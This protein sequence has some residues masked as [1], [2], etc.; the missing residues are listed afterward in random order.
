MNVFLRPESAAAWSR[1][2]HLAQH[3]FD[4][5]HGNILQRVCLFMWFS[6]AR[7]IGVCKELAS[8]DGCSAILLSHLSQP[9]LP[10]TAQ[11]QV[12]LTVLG[13]AV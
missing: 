12:K 11:R 5:S 6:N 3:K 7:R 10:V 9:S 1:A 13:I 8:S 4:S 2:F